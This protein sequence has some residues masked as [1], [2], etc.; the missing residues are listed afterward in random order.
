M[1]QTS[2]ALGE[3]VDFAHVLVRMVDPA[4]LNSG[5]RRHGTRKCW[6]VDSRADFAGTGVIVG[7]RTAANG[8]RVWEGEEVGYVFIPDE[9]LT[10]YLV[11]F[12][13]HRK[14]V[15]VLAEHLT[16][17]ELPP[18]PEPVEEQWTLGNVSGYGRDVRVLTLM[19]AAEEVERLDRIGSTPGNETSHEDSLSF[20]SSPLFQP[21]RPLRRADFAEFLRARAAEAQ[22]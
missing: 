16:P 14:P 4:T 3:R 1:T 10:V 9:H 11:A 22:S 5:V 8:E 21:A 6:R 7:K 13:M 17:H 15:H 19:E 18:E 12:A 2:F 20:A